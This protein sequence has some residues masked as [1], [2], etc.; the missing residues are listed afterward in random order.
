[1]CPLL[2]LERW[3]L[4]CGP[5]LLWN[6]ILIQMATGSQKVRKDTGESSHGWLA[7]FVG[8][9]DVPS[10]PEAPGGVTAMSFLLFS[11]LR[12]YP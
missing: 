3:S 5:P 1:M 12:T 8:F 7:G 6:P 9:A 11:S 10:N 2:D 4:L